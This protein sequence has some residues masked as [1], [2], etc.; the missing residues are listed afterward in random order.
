MGIESLDIKPDI[1]QRDAFPI[2]DI[3]LQARNSIYGERETSLLFELLHLLT[4]PRPM[5]SRRRQFAGPLIV[6]LRALAV[7]GSCARDQLVLPLFILV[8][9]VIRQ[10]RWIVF[11][12]DCVPAVL[13]RLRIEQQTIVNRAVPA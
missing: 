10:I 4:F 13:G 3:A 2:V 1:L 7:T 11:S 6:R 5:A 8:R 9:E 12:V